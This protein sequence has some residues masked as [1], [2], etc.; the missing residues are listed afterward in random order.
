MTLTGL[1]PDEDIRT[2]AKSIQILLEFDHTMASR[3]DRIST[4][5]GRAYSEGKI[6]DKHY[7]HLWLL[8]GVGMESIGNSESIYFCLNL[9][10]GDTHPTALLEVLV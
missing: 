5:R 1:A 8:K 2:K 3:V 4:A 6:D 10:H 7:S 9:M